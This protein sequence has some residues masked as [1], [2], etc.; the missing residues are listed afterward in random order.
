ML[1][2]AGH[3]PEQPRAVAVIGTGAVRRVGV[4]EPPAWRCAHEWSPHATLNTT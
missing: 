4:E 2:D 3:R 1:D